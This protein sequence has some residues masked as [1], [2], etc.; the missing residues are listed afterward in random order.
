MESMPII[1]R[2]WEE[3][4]SALRKLGCYV[5]GI[6]ETRRGGQSIFV[7]A[8]YTVYCSGESGGE[9]IGF[10]HKADLKHPARGHT[11]AQEPKGKPH[12]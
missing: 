3:A 2:A 4:L 5:I 10:T 7:E 9:L 11:S 8:G 1:G 6:Q 12:K